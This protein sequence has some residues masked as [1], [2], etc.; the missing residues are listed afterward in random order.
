MTS[1]TLLPAQALQ[2]FWW[3]L[4]I[5]MAH[6]PT[7]LAGHTL[8]R[9]KVCNKRWSHNL[10]APDSYMCML[11][12]KAS[13]IAWCTVYSEFLFQGYFAQSVVRTIVL[14][15]CW[16]KIT[17][18]GHWWTLYCTSMH[19]IK[20]N[21]LHSHWRLMM[22]K[23]WKSSTLSPLECLTCIHMRLSHAL[24]FF[25]SG[26]VRDKGPPCSKQTLSTSVSVLFVLAVDNNTLGFVFL[27]KS[28]KKEI[29]QGHQ[30]SL[31]G[32]LGCWYV[33]LSGADGQPYHWSIHNSLHFIVLWCKPIMYGYSGSCLTFTVQ[34]KV[35]FFYVDCP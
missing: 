1:I 22:M 27:L 19:V 10:P 18:Q 34:F 28:D 35:Y 8:S 15:A 6:S 29:W 26:S 5:L 21:T 2:G 3:D 31:S 7:G 12:Q 13:S 33:N 4:S 17:R 24:T 14:V 11:H 30:C 16:W 20:H 9:L 25:P 32:M 23:W